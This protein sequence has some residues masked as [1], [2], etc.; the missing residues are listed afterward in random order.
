MHTITTSFH[1]V[2]ALQLSYQL[3]SISVTDSAPHSAYP[4]ISL[5]VGVNNTLRVLHYCSKRRDK[6]RQRCVKNVSSMSKHLAVN[7]GKVNV[8]KAIVIT[9]PLAN[10]AGVTEQALPEMYTEIGM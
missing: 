5:V 7:K 9:I 6:V 2:N 3:P 1:K 10:P 8:Y 4:F